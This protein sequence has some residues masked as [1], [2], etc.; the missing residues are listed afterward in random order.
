MLSSSTSAALKELI[1][2]QL[3]ADK[4]RDLKLCNSLI[5][6]IMQR[7]RD[8]GKWQNMTDTA[9]R[10]SIRWIYKDTPPASP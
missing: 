7:N 6:V 8:P 1:T 2:C 3:L 5:D 4:Q 9:N 10:R